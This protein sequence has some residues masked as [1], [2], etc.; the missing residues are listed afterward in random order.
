[1]QKLTEE[2]FAKAAAAGELELADVKAVCE[3]ESNGGGFD[4]NGLPIILFEG[5]VFSRLTQGTYDSAHPTISFH[6][7]TR[8]YY[9]KGA[10]ATVRNTKEHVR[11]QEATG[12]NR[13]AALMSASWGLFQI[14]GENYKSAG[15]PDIQSFTN[16]MYDGEGR[17]LDA[18]I[19]FISREKKKRLDGV[20]DFLINTLRAHRWA[21][22]AYGYNGSGYA[23]NKYD[24]KLAQAHKKFTS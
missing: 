21:D 2:D 7:W 3:V 23:T 8:Q 6:D 13:D 24:L 22:F 4:D 15:H 16:A 18:F 1:M 19:S 20:R 5:H 9:S 11:L 17:H 12:L 10:T 14:M